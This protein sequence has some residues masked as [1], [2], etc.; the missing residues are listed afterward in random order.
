MGGSLMLLLAVL[1]VELV[2]LAYAA[3]HAFD[4]TDLP[5]L[6]WL[7]WTLGWVWFVLPIV[8]VFVC[9]GLCKNLDEEQQ[10]LR[11]VGEMLR[12]ANRSLGTVTAELREE[13]E[14]NRGVTAQLGAE[15]ER[16]RAAASRAARNTRAARAARVAAEAQVEAAVAALSV[17][18]AQAD[19]TAARDPR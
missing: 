10:E 16:N 9:C 5:A 8:L 7:A 4:P 6:S 15:I 3:V 12:N 13:I 14:R 18:E 19:A 1:C 17:D 2:A 11:R